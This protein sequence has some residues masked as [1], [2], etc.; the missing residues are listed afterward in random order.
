[1]H[2]DVSYHGVIQRVSISDAKY[3]SNGLEWHTRG[4]Q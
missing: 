4:E 1:M 3:K 2:L